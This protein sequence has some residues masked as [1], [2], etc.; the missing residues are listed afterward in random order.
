MAFITL[1]RRNGRACV[2]IFDGPRCPYSLRV[3]EGNRIL[4]E[5]EA[6]S[7]DEVVLMATM[8]EEQEAHSLY[9]A[10]PP[11]RRLAGASAA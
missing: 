6:R 9:G 11:D 5:E 8:W 4:R 1:W 3:L 10:V 2:A 7:G